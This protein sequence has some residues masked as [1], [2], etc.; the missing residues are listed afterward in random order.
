M[1][2]AA[3]MI[4]PYFSFV[5]HNLAKFCDDPGP[6]HWEATMKALQYFW[7]TK[8]LGITQDGVMSRDPTM[9]TYVDSDHVTCLDS[10]RSVSGGAV[11]LSG[12]AISW[13]S[14]AH[15]V[16]AL[17]SSE[18]EYVALTEIANETGARV[19]HAYFETRRG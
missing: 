4:R 16:A 8:D 19:H 18:R 3:I 15:R 5:A 7:Q 12:G 11:M 13:F 2:W 1:M 9:S 10:R 6:V 14:R 17:V